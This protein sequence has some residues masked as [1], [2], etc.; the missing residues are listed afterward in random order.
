MSA[1]LLCRF[2]KWFVTSMNGV[3]KHLLRKSQPGHLVFVGEKRATGEFYPKMVS[4]PQLQIV[5]SQA[6]FRQHNIQ[7]VKRKNLTSHSCHVQ[8]SH[9]GDHQPLP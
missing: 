4:I 1:C 9:I 6:I 8:T 3:R 2:R 5:S 7:N